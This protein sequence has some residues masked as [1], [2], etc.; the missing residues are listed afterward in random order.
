MSPV[1]PTFRKCLAW[2]VDFLANPRNS[3]KMAV[4][5]LLWEWVLCGLIIRFIK[6]TEVDW[7][8][9]MIQVRQILDGERRYDR[10]QGPTGPI[11]YPAGH[12]YLFS[13]L[14]HL[15][16]GGRI[17][18]GQMFFAGLYVV[19]L[20][21]VM[22][23]Y[24]QCKLPP[25]SLLLLC[26]SKRIHS[27]FLLRMHN[28]TVAMLGVYVMAWCLTKQR[29][30]AAVVWFSLALSVKMSVLLFAPGLAFLLVAALGWMPALRLG[31]LTSVIQVA[32]GLPF[33]LSYP[34]EYITMAFDFSRR[35]FFDI[36]YN[37]QFM[38]YDTFFSPTFIRGLLVAHVS[39]LLAFATYRWTR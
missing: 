7:S 33:L 39:V 6:Y 20:A 18:Q 34:Y 28:D 14:Y 31:L 22:A 29:W 36:S 23:L 12:V 25:Y 2:G 21:V 17:L 38:G 19:S 10:I 1:V 3:F 24:I 4:L 15:T 11:V 35:F 8:T 16:D 37:W 30:T 13:A 32:L 27:V 9:Y 5:L 26:V